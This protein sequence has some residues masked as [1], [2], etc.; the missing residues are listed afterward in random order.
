MIVIMTHI[1]MHTS[2][3]FLV[4]AVGKGKV[5]IEFIHYVMLSHAHYY[6]IRVEIEDAYNGLSMKCILNFKYGT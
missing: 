4:I 1:C 6:G 2:D 3:I 5:P